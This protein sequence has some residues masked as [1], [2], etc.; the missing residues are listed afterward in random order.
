MILYFSGTGNSRYAA[1]FLADHLGDEMLDVGAEIRAG[2]TL[3]CH[4]L[5]PWVFVCP[6]YGWQLPHIFRDALLKAELSGSRDVYFVMTCGS[7]IGSAGSGAAALSEKKGLRYRGVAEI[8]MPENYIAMFDAP[9]SSEA[10]EIIRKAEP[11]MQ[12]AY[13][14]IRE[15][16]DLP[17]KRISAADRLKSGLVNRVFYQ[18]FVKADPFFATESCI[19]C[20]RCAALCPL[21]NISLVEGKPRWGSDCTHCMACICGCGAEAIEY[22]RKS[23]GKP[24]YQCPDYGKNEG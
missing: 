7:D 23:L 19:G 12:T 20:G 11:A 6:T 8:V 15:E 16:K 18:L 4:S 22:G 10:A 21:N 3:V 17:P 9:K 13:E 2:R 14:T 5:R 1:E 24:R